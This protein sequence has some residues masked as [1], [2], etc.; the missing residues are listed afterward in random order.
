M[1]H[2][3]ATPV[4]PA[5]TLRAQSLRVAFFSDSLPERN[6][7]GAYY[8]DLISQLE[9]HLGAVEV[10]QP[11]PRQ[12][13]RPLLSLPM[14]GDPLQ[15]LVTPNFPRIRRGYR[16]LRPH[17]VIA[18]TPGLFGCLGLLL[19]RRSGARFFT[20]FHTDFEHLA[21]MYWTRV[22]RF[23]AS[24]YLRN[25]NKMLCRRSVA[26]LINNSRL[27]KDVTRLGGIRTEVMGTPLQPAFL[28]PP[29]PPPAPAMRQVCF[30]GRLA[31]EKNINLIIQSAIELPEIQFVIVGDGPLR[32][33]LE[34]QARDCKNVRFTGWLERRA[35]IEILDQS[36]LLLLPSK[37]E[38]FG[39]VALEAMARGRPALV[40]TAAGIHDWPDLENGLIPLEP[41][42]CLTRVLRSCLDHPPEFWTEKAVAARRA[43]EDLNAKTIHQWIQVL[44]K[45]T[46]SPDPLNPAPRSPA[47]ISIHDCM[48][49][50]WSRVEEILVRLR[51]HGIAKCSLLIVPGKEWHPS[52]IKRMREL[53]DQGYELIAHGW[54]HQTTPRRFVHLIHAFF[55]SRNVAEHLDLDSTAILELLQRSYRW[56]IDNNLPEP[57]CYIPPAWALGPLKKSDLQCSPF[58]MIEVT[59]GVL[60]CSNREYPQMMPLPVVGFEA[61]TFLRTGALG[62]WNVCQ[63]HRIRQNGPALRIAIHPYDFELNL[64]KQLERVLAKGWKSLTYR[65]LLASLEPTQITEKLN[66][67]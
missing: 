64:Q 19:A 4:E 3:P 17:L 6:G 1:T 28:E 7:T 41:G 51:D 48:P 43:A 27:K 30:A 59:R 15:R 13:D 44:E 45:Y 12:T 20:A 53:S 66:G 50:T 26:V 24:T 46:G 61:D 25:T 34:A 55:L 14:P 39:S 16:Q 35:L 2:L 62:P 47:L 10:F 56:F 54:N 5:A 52:H 63:C 18:V 42:E 31:V 40:S 38:T 11:C 33:Q 32:G 23:I 65:D 22:S 49:E 36:S 58:R 67:Y 57:N 8:H 37:V 60:D 9:P 21:R 29:Q